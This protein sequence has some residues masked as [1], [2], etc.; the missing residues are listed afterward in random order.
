[1]NIS[2]KAMELINPFMKNL[3]SKVDKSV[4]VGTIIQMIGVCKLNDCS[5]EEAFDIFQYILYETDFDEAAGHDYLSVYINQ[6]NNK[7]RES[8]R[9]AEFEKVIFG[10]IQGAPAPLIKKDTLD[11]GRTNIDYYETIARLDEAEYEEREME[12][13]SEAE[14][15]SIG[16]TGILDSSFWNNTDTITVAENLQAAYGRVPLSGKA[17][18]LVNENSGEKIP[19]TKEVFS[20]GKDASMVDYAIPGNTTVS[21]KHAEI[22]K[23]GMHFFLSDKGSTNK[24][25]VEGREI[26]PE[27]FVEIHNGTKFKL[28][29]EEFTFYF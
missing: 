19:V 27:E 8:F 4:F 12:L 23:R 28:S 1:M 3:S 5:D 18:F 2:K 13:Y 25:Y 11:S 14:E 6:V 15:D 10:M 17:P 16:D 26:R 21:R 29:N 22:I 7:R 9:M 24:T 20:L